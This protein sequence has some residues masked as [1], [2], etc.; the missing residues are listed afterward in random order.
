M[1]AHVESAADFHAAVAAGVDQIAHLPGFRGDPAAALP[2]P[3]RYEIREADARMAGRRNIAVVTTIAGLARDADEQ[4][5]P[6][7]RRA[8][9]RLYTANLEMLRK[10]GVPIAVGSDEYGDTSVGEALY[11]HALGVFRPAELL[12]MWT[13]TTARTI[14]PNRLIG[15]L[16]PGYE[17]SFLSLSGNPLADFSAV[18]Q[19]RLRVKQGRVIDVPPPPDEGRL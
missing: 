14:F 13:E 4:R 2:G 9:D 12:R 5:D 10:Q 18:K 3:S 19:I 16:E 7:L 8:A 6:V 11:L 15:R 1:I 17:A